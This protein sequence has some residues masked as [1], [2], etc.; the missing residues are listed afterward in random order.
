MPLRKQLSRHPSL[1]PHDL[2]IYHTE[3]TRIL[4]DAIEWKDVHRGQK[5]GSGRICR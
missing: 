3:L 5:S 2:I 4:K 1:K